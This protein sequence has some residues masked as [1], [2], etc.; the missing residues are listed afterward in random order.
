VRVGAVVR[1]G[2]VVR[3]LMREHVCVLCVPECVHAY[4]CER[5]DGESPWSMAA[6]PRV[7]A[8][9][10]AHVRVLIRLPA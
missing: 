6:H 9:V 8:C 1:W 3:M 2:V 7:L 10:C 5:S 4:L